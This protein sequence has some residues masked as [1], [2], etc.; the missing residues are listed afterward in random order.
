M[1]QGVLLKEAA[2]DETE[3]EDEQ[4]HQQQHHFNLS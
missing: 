2:E 4:P 3:I 1:E